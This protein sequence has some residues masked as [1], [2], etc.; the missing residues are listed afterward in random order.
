MIVSEQVWNVLPS[1]TRTHVRDRHIG[2]TR[3]PLRAEHR[4]RNKTQVFRTPHKRR[5]S[6]EHALLHISLGTQEH[7][8]FGQRVARTYSNAQVRIM[9]HRLLTYTFSS[10]FAYSHAAGA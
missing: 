6:P 4:L 9:H 8:I 5:T 7:G 3:F 10:H 1:R 2:R